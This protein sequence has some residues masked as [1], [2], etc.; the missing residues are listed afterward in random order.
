[1]SDP[2]VDLLV[3]KMEKAEVQI[4]ANAKTM[5]E[6][7]G[8]IAN[9]KDQT[10][11]MTR[12]TEIVNQLQKQMSATKFPVE[13]MAGLADLLR[14]NQQVMQHPPKQKV[15]YEHK[16]HKLIWV[17]IGLFLVVILLIHLQLE[18]NR[19]LEAFQM[20]DIAWRHVKL[21][22]GTKGLKDLQ[23]VEQDYLNDPQL[24]TKNVEQQEL[25]LLQKEESRRL[26]AEKER[27]AAELRRQ[28]GD[29]AKADQPKQKTTKQPKTKETQPLE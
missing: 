17:V 4:N 7:S 15:V 28:A 5:L 9:M 11:N 25:I 2:V 24:M 10:S 23:Q 8:T 20:H 13:Q 27:E 22:S 16:A 3:D 18:K 26:A 21:K 14:N 29:P 6:V 12:L 19:E 1:M